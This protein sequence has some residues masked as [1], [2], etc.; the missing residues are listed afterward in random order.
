MSEFAVIAAA[1]YEHAGRLRGFSG[2]I[3]TARGRVAR[4]AS[5]AS[6][7]P[8]AGA[9]EHLTGHVHARLADFAAATDALDRAVT[10]AGDAHAR[11]DACVAESTS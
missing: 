3:D 2:E 4:G 7:T 11:A 10:G 1:L 8:A 9:V 6:A 5:A